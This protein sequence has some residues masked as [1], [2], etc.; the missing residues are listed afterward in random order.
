MSLTAD[1]VDFANARWE[2][3]RLVVDLLDPDLYRRDPHDVWGW[4][5]ATE[6]VYHDARNG[7]WGVTRHADLMDVERRSTV[8][9]SGQGYRAVWSPSEVNMIAQDDP[10]HRQQRMLVQGGFTK[11]SVEARHAEVERLVADVL[12]AALAD[13]ADEMEVIDAVAGQ[14][15]ARLTARLLGYPES[16]WA[17][18]KSWSERLMRTDMRERDGRVFREFIAANMEFMGALGEIARERYVNPADDLISAWIHGRIDGEPLPPEAIAHE[19]GLFISGGAETTRTAISHGLRAF[20]DHPDQ[21]DALADDPDLVPGAVEEVLRWVTPLNNMFRR[22]VADD[23]IGDQPVERGDRIIMLYPSANRDEEVFDD[24]FRFDIRRAP[25]PHLAF[26]FGTHLC[27][28]THV[29]RATLA[30][31]FGQM[32]RRLTDLRVISEPDV[33]RNI[34]A[35]AVVSFELGFGRR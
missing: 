15:P 13:G 2:G 9:A 30:S 19:V 21:W 35:R 7:L 14:V 26:G 29:A 28:G 20:V 1:P 10:R 4:M 22:A 8:F 3:G 6:P 17:D 34:F 31:V 16:R 27:I 23:R 25:N 32:S 11:K 24:P 18:L 5:R 12:D 33:E